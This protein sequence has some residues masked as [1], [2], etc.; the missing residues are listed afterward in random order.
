[1][2]NPSASVGTRKALIPPRRAAARSGSVTASAIIQSAIGTWVVQILRPL[3][4][5][6]LPSA[7]A[8]VRILVASE[9]ASG[10][11]IPKHIMVSP[12]TRPREHLGPGPLRDPL[13][14]PA[15]AEGDLQWLMAN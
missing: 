15:R 14:H 4:R 3:S 10:S 1:M 12:A 5:H 6:P 9:P 2:W 13:Q 7:T 11:D 8:R